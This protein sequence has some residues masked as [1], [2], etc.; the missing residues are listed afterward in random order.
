MRKIKKTDL[1]YKSDKVF[2]IIILFSIFSCLQIKI[3]GYSANYFFLLL[4]IMQIIITQ[5]FYR[6]FPFPY[7][8]FFFIYLFAVFFVF[9]LLRISDFNLLLMQI[10]SF[11]SFM[12]LFSFCLFNFP[13]RSLEA[14]K[15]GLIIGSFFLLANFFDANRYNEAILKDGLQRISYILFF[16]YIFTLE[17]IIFFERTNNFKFFFYLILNVII[18]FSL[19]YYQIR[20]AYILLIVFFFFNLNAAYFKYYFYIFIIILIFFL[21]DILK[22]TNHLLFFYDSMLNIFNLEII[23]QFNFEESS[24]AKRLSLLNFILNS[25]Q[26]FTSSGYLGIWYSHPTIS[27]AHN[28][29]L[30]IIYRIGILGFIFFIFIIFN[31]T[32]FLKRTDKFIFLSFISFLIYGIFHETIKEPTGMFIFSYLFGYMVYSSRKEKSIRRLRSK[33][34]NKNKINKKSI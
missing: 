25:N 9:I 21:F 4:P 7:L 15:I 3:N 28:Q 2:Y 32:M 23:H 26:F 19:I 10:L 33:L 12:S 34:I 1:F 8:H 29:Y 18:L 13:A 11:L 27:S 14:F 17:K 30:D 5:K 20:A 24:E 22:F 31:L 16:G 6:N